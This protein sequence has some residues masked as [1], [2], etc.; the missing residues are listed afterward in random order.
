MTEATTPTDDAPATPPIPPARRVMRRIAIGLVVLLGLFLVLGLLAGGKFREKQRRLVCAHNVKCLGLA[1][2]MY[3]GENDGDFP[4]TADLQ[5]L[6]DRELTA[7]GKIWSCPSA[8]VPGTTARTSNFIYI[9]SGLRDDNLTPAIVP[10]MYDAPDNH[11]GPWIN[12]VF[13]D[14]H[15]EG[16]AAASIEEAAALKGWTLP[17]AV[18]GVSDSEVAP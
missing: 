4:P 3:S 11:R 6:N 16:V 17:P 14:G 7:D 8:S 5:I 12:V 18:T 2:L 15:A 13:I 10:V 1:L 9:G